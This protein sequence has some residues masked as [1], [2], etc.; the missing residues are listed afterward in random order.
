MTESNSPFNLPALRDYISTELLNDPETYI[1]TD[2]DLLISGLLDSLNA[3]QLA[4]KIEQTCN[5]TIP[6]E[7]MIVENFGSLRKI[8]AYIESRI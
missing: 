4:K 7:D 5:F 1:E 8:N 3:I 6:P 2:D